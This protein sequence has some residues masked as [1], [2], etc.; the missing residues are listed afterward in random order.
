[1]AF[2]GTYLYD[3]TA[4]T[5]H[6]RDRQPDVAEPWLL[7]GLNGNTTTLTYRPTGRGSGVTHL[8]AGDSQLD[9]PN[10]SVEAAGL[11]DH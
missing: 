1:M 2:S 5:P 10:V 6:E 9:E 4:W 3:G 11:A 8:R 7:V